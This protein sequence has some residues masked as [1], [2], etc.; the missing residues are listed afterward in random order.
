MS[1]NRMPRILRQKR[2]N[3]NDFAFVKLNG[4]HVYLGTWGN[5]D[6][7][8]QYNR[9][10][11]EWLARGKQL[12]PPPDTVAIMECI[13]IY[14][15]YARQYYQQSKSSLERVNYSMNA[16]LALYGR[17]PAAEF[18][19]THLRAVRGTG[20]LENSDS[21][22]QRTYQAHCEDVPV[23]RQSGFDFRNPLREMQHA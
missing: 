17:M 1:K 2:K 23:L 5:H 3:G 21:I 10:I 6:V 20:T 4:K 19:A 11:S 14:L 18:T 13:E 22:H 8:E 12:P 16:L 7:Q 9:V 15:V